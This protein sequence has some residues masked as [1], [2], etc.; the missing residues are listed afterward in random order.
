MIVSR[1]HVNTAD[2][3][4]MELQAIDVSVLEDGLE[5]HVQ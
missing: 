3:V 5:I 1:T 2:T 4:V